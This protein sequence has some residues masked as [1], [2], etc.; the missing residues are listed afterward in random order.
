MVALFLLGLST[1]PIAPDFPFSMHTIISPLVGWSILL[2]FSVVN[3]RSSA[4]PRILLVVLEYNVRNCNHMHRRVS[5]I[6]I[7]SDI[8]ALSLDIRVSMEMFDTV[9]E[10]NGSIFQSLA[11]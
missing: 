11:R 4:L 1:L 7:N 5:S 10:T 8:F 9:N 2:L 6:E 3:I